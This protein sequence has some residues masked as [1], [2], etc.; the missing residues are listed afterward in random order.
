MLTRTKLSIEKLIFL[1][2]KLLC[3]V[4]R[5]TVRSVTQDNGKTD[6]TSSTNYEEHIRLNKMLPLE[7]FWEFSI[8]ANCYIVLVLGR[9]E[10]NTNLLITDISAT[11]QFDLTQSSSQASISSFVTS[12]ACQAK[13]ATPKETSFSLV[14]G[15]TWQVQLN[16]VWQ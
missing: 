4:S 8:I 3:G 7:K 14:T 5:K 10:F 16:L 12:Q 11:E 2:R 15:L 13:S 9:G 6:F 1:T